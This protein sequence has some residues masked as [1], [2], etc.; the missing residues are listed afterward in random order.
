MTESPSEVATIELL[1]NLSQIASHLL[2]LHTF[3]SSHGAAGRNKTLVRDTCHV[4]VL[5]S[6][7]HVSCIGQV[8]AE[9][10]PCV[11]TDLRGRLA[12]LI[13]ELGGVL[14]LHGGGHLLSLGNLRLDRSRRVVT[15]SHGSHGLCTLVHDCR[16]VREAPLGV[17]V[18]GELI[19][20]L[21]GLD[22]GSEQGHYHC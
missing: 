20:D 14:G 18:G 3:R 9:L 2:D 6:L 15:P 13:D 5:S 19:V 16:E 11:A 7:N 8:N 21:D 10:L 1:S 12:D 22:P 17:G 4:S